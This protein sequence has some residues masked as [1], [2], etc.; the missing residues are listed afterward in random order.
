M[1]SFFRQVIIKVIWR[2]NK[3]RVRDTHD[4]TE[5]RQRPSV[6]NGGSVS[7]TPEHGGLPAIPWATRV[8]PIMNQKLMRVNISPL[9]LSKGRTVW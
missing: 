3:C 1:V 8:V 7:Q 5:N 2:E 4:K 6:L 9:W